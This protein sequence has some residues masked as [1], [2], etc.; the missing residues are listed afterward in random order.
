MQRDEKV[1][2]LRYPGG[3]QRQLF[4]F[5]HTL[6]PRDKI[7]N[8]YVEPFVGGGSV[9]FSV[10]PHCAILSDTNV[11]LIDLY[12]G[13]CDYP[14]NVWQLFCEFPP[15]KE[16]FYE[17]R[18]KRSE[19]LELPARA[20]R[21]LYLNRTCFKGMW[22]HNLNG[23]FN[24]GYGGQDRRWVIN[25]ENLIQVSERLKG[26][27]LKCCDF[28]EIIDTC[29]QGDFIFLDPPYRPGA[30]EILHEHYR[31]GKFTFTDQQRLARA[32]ERASLRGCCWAMTNS[33]HPEI[34]AL[35]PAHRT[36]P[37]AKGTGKRIGQITQITGEVLILNGT[38]VN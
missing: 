3:K 13:I 21:T 36:F 25:E 23:E 37:L 26:A 16:A 1:V 11:E 31:F 4:N 27:S 7:K 34:V 15:T 35:Y 29:E 30:R 32:L 2:F 22:R 14:T 10:V 18:R 33:A 12:R 17:I 9:F 6:P 24:V 8:R 5:L 28:E 19:D 20:A 38:E